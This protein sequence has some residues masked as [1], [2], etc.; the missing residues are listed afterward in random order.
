MGGDGEALRHRG[1]KSSSLRIETPKLCG[2]RVPFIFERGADHL[3]G[4]PSVV[5]T[6]EPSPST[7]YGM[8]LAGLPFDIAGPEPVSWRIFTLL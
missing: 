4:S 8:L 5:V 6:D 1:L 7:I 2:G 3:A